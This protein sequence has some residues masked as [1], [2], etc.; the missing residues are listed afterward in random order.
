ML[1]GSGT[2][3]F[4]TG[5]MGIFPRRILDMRALW[6]FPAWLCLSAPC[7]AQALDRSPLRIC[8]DADEWPPYTYYVRKNQQQ[9]RELTGYSVDVITRIL[10]KQR[11]PFRID[12]LP[13]KRCLSAIDNDE[14][15]LMALSASKNPEREKQFLF[16]LPYYQTHYY[17]FYSRA[18]YP[19]GVNVAGQADLGR[20]R[21]GGVKGYAYSALT[22]VDKNAMLRAADYPTLAR[23]LQAD[24]FDLFAEDYEVLAGLDRLGVTHIVDNPAIGRMPLP[25]MPGNAFHMI[26][27]RK[28]PRGAQ[29]QQLVDRELR[30]MQASGELEQLLRRYVPR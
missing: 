12:L 7:Q 20:Y 11:I 30:Q 1:A 16:S 13:W 5:G 26:F 28:N 6:L 18:K 3:A 4:Y 9:T 8:D 25:G 24:R 27:S 23:M 15:Y 10:D 29:L 19:D 17:V 2:V 14:Q 21:L 22:A